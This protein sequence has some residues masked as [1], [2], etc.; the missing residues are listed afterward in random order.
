MYF[1]KGEPTKNV[2]FYKI[3][4]DGYSMGVNRKEIPGCQIPEALE[5]FTKYA[6]HGKIPPKTK[7]SFIVPADWIKQI[8]PRLKE[9]IIAETTEQQK[10]K[11]NE[12]R[13]KEIEKS[14][15]QLKKGKI[16]EKEY[17]EKIWQFDNV[18]ENN[19]QNEIAKRIEKAHSYS[20]NLQNY[21]SI[22]SDDQIKK[23]QSAFKGIKI[24]N[25]ANIDARYQ[26]LLNADSK[27]DLQ[28]LASF[29]SE[30]ALEMDIAREYLSKA[31][32]KDKKMQELEE[33]FK[34]AQKYPKVP[35]SELLI[36]LLEERKFTIDDEKVY[37]E[38]TIKTKTNEISVSNESKGEGLKVKKRIL[39]KKGD[40]VVGLLH[41]QNGSFAI[42]DQEYVSTGTFIPFEINTNEV[43][44]KYLFHS[45]RTAFEKLGVEDATGRENYKVD[46]ILGLQIPLP[47]LEI[48]Q[49]IVEKIERQKGIAEGVEKLQKNIVIDFDIFENFDLKYI[50]EFAELNP[51]KDIENLKD[52][53]LVSFV[54]MED[55]SEELGKIINNIKRELRGVKKGY[56]YFRNND[57]IFAKITP[58]MEN[59]KSALAENLE[60]GIGFGSTEFHVI[61]VKKNIAL[62]KY[63]YYLIRTKYFRNCAKE[64]MT[65]ASGHKRVPEEFMLSFKYPI[66]SLEIQKQIV[67]QLDK[68]MEA[69]EKVRELKKQAE[70]RLNKTLEEVW[71][72]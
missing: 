46:D 58:C 48:Q 10:I 21:K 34:E 70:E 7:N 52:N 38:P 65:G 42:C 24:K 41:T 3:T 53:D 22:L 67:A 44:Q 49:E 18:V 43:N 4:N 47:P 5:L 33:I 54:P 19:I 45:L 40:L 6:K 15:G 32:K 16:T 64:K 27:T 37:L 61:R 59:G 60:N 25:G 35:L 17:K 31:E 69:L 8:D 12:K 14:D 63:I 1:E 66:P 39:L 56:T 30:S 26:E 36:N 2:W 29:N 57:V 55:V 72:E 13:E 51:K 23:W 28:I 62:S 9:R 20:F 11:F 71:G 50:N 68:E